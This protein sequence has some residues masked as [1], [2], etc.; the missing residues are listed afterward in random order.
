MKRKEQPI[1]PFDSATAQVYCKN[2]N[3]RVRY[4][5]SGHRWATLE[6]TCAWSGC[7]AAL[8]WKI[9]PRSP[10]SAAITWS[11]W[12][13][14]VFAFFPRHPEQR[15]CARLRRC[16]GLDQQDWTERFLKAYSAAGQAMDDERGWTAF[17]FN[18]GKAASS[19]TT[20]LSSACAGSAQFC[21]SS[22][23]PPQPSFP[24]ATSACALTGGPHSFHGRSP[25]HCP[26]PRHPHPRLVRALGSNLPGR[27]RRLSALSHSQ[28]R[29]C[30]PPRTASAERMPHRSAVS[31]R[32]NLP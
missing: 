11:R 22:S 1:V 5:R 16:R 21:S 6:K 4:P 30:E 12:S 20:P 18:V 17:A 7:P 19:A 32:V 23:L 27:L 10:R 15:D 3:F 29:E 26:R 2:G 14:R 31:P 28:C 9:S 8:R 25:L 24:F 13:R